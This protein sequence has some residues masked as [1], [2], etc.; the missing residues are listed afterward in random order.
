MEVLHVSCR[1]WILSLYKIEWTRDL[2]EVSFIRA[3]IPFTGLISHDLT[4]SQRLHLIISLALRV[5]FSTKEFWEGTNM[6]II[7]EYISKGNGITISKRYL[8]SHIDYSLFI[9]DNMD[10]PGGQYDEW[11]PVTESQIWSHFYMVDFSWHPYN[12]WSSVGIKKMQRIKKQN[13]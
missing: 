9:S 7:G 11:K 10:D 4:I 1:H 6:Q 3:L 8:Y 13:P 5:R 12:F 2:C